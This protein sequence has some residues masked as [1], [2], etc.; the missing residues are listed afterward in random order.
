M[1]LTQKVY[2]HSIKVWVGFEVA[3]RRGEAKEKSYPIKDE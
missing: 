3:Q 2:K 1:G